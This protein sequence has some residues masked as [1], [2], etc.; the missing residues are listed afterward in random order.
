VWLLAGR[1]LRP[2]DRMRRDVDAMSGSDLHERVARPPN[3]DEVAHLADTLNS[4]L[5][6]IEVGAQ[7]QRQFV[8]DASH[9]LRSPLTRMRAELEVDLAH[10]GSADPVAT[11]RS[12]LHEVE[13][14]QQL[15]DDL[16]RLASEGAGATPA[17]EPVDLGS[18]VVAEAARIRVTDGPAVHVDEPASTVVEGDGAGLARAVRN[19]ADNA[20]RHAAANVWMDVAQDNG[21]AIVTVADD[22]PG[23]PSQDRERVFLRFARVD[24]S[25]TA[26]TGGAGLGLAIALAIV[27]RHGGTLTVDDHPSGGARFVMTLPARR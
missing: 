11:H 10:P 26:G 13:G 19:L 5:E 2:V 22:G 15:V 24:E 23:V 8:A 20:R 16:L 3:E 1:A 4:L 12:V 6:R 27:Q 25:R 18:I 9:E 7:Q 21:Y 14:M 17:R